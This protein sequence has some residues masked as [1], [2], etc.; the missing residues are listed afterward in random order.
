M[1]FFHGV[2]AGGANQMRTGAAVALDGGEAGD[3][4]EGNR[5]HHVLAHGKMC[6]ITKCKGSPT[7]D[8][9]N[10]VFSMFIHMYANIFM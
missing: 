3:G 1:F 6:E 5:Q 2:S 10:N 9:N 4:E 8:Q 7:Y